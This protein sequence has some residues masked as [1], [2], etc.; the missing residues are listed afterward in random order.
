MIV[1]ISRRKGHSYTFDRL[2]LRGM[3]IKRGCSLEASAALRIIGRHS[4]ILRCVVVVG[5]E[6]SDVQQFMAYLTHGQERQRSVNRLS[7]ANSDAE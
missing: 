2:Q 6:S 1:A 3:T 7:N 4:L 5:D